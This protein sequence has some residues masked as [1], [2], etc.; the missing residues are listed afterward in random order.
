[1]RFSVEHFRA[2]LCGCD[3]RAVRA[4]VVGADV[5]HRC[6]SAHA[7][8]STLTHSARS[9]PAVVKSRGSNADGQIEVV[10]VSTKKR[11]EEARSSEK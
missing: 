11:R 9:A 6:V 1:M 3:A 7:H 4:R 2:G 10:V 8:V 5:R